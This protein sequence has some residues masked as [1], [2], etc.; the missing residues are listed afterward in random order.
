[1]EKRRWRIMFNV[2]ALVFLIAGL[3]VIFLMSIELAG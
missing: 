2:S 3:P 1:M